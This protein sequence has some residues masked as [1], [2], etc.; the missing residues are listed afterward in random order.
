MPP[1]NSADTSQLSSM[2]NTAYVWW[3]TTHF[4]QVH[5]S[6]AFPGLPDGRGADPCHIPVLSSSPTTTD[7]LCNCSIQNPSQQSPWLAGICF[8]SGIS[9][10]P[11]KEGNCGEAILHNM[12]LSKQLCSLAS[13]QLSQ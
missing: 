7:T 6:S 13:P 11:L 5:R 12:V 1:Q 10:N 2:S 3:A 4:K 9:A 8:Q